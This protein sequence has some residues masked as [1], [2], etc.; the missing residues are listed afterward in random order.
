MSYRIADEVVRR[1][2]IA[3]STAPGC[4]ARPGRLTQRMV[5]CRSFVRTDRRFSYRLFGA[6]END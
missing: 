5:A 1:E 2:C 4:P 6:G 3:R